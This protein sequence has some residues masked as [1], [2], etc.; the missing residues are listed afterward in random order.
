MLSWTASA[1]ASVVSYNVY[2]GTTAG[3]ENLKIGSVNSPTTNFT[4][5]TVVSGNTYFYVVTAVG[6]GSVESVVSGEA[7]AVVP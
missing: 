4:D 6:P 3:G 7:S 5:M 1:T 2:R